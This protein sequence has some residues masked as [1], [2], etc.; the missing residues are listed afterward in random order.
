MTKGGDKGGEEERD[1]D[2]EAAELE[3][4]GSF[5]S[6]ADAFEQAYNFRFE[7][8]SLAQQSFA[9]PSFPRRVEGSMRRTDDR[10]KRARQE[11]SAR[12]E[13]E[14]QAK[15][16]ELDQL[17]SLK[18]Q[19][20]AEKLRQLR[21]A[22][23]S[24]NRIDGDA[25][26]GLDLNEDFDPA[27]HDEMMRRQ[28]GEDYYEQPGDDVKPEWDDEIDD[29][30]KE[31]GPEEGS[32]KKSKKDKK[33]KKSD[34][35]HIDMDADFEGEQEERKLSK[36]ER[37]QLKKQE[38]KK[39]KRESEKGHSTDGAVSADEMDADAEPEAPV[40][41][42]DRKKRAKELM[43]EYYNLGY[44][45]MIGDQ[46]TRFK[47]TSVPKSDYGMSATEILLA[48]DADLNKVV[49]L[50]RLQPYNQRS[51]PGNLGNRL[52]R[53][54][55]DLA[56]RYGGEDDPSKRPKKQRLGKKERQKLK[57]QQSQDGE[58]TQSK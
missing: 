28:F 49:G 22:S 16:R 39:K 21:E 29:I 19:A 14:K 6:A 7:D 25:F 37:K 26:D 34:D 42:P 54:R 1:W 24:D 11:R 45:D 51:K 35:D 3:S 27:K 41:E 47:Y 32:R 5:D 20:I 56:E 46:P 43:D 2:A 4:D 13:E 58:G 30:L 38:K 53:F 52:K 57:A 23:G 10:R 12:K 55:E 8:P 50:K 18:R 36:K 40:S 44:E 33:K 31:T 9:I 17:K 48:D 15:M